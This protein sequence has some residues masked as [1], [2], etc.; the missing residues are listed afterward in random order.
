MCLLLTSPANAITFDVLVLPIDGFSNKENYYNFEEASEIIAND[1]IKDFNNTKGKIKSPDL[2]EVRAKL[3]KNSELKSTVISTLDKYKNT[4]RIDYAAVKKIGNDFS[5]KSVL[6]ISSSAVTN[7]NTNKR[8]IWEIL[9]ISS[10][11]QTS[12]PY[13][14][15]TSAVLLDTVNDL[16]MWSNNFSTKLGS[17]NNTF[18]AENFAQANAELEK[19][20]FYSEMIISPSISQNITLRFFPK[21]IRPL[22][23][24]IENNNGGALKFDRTVPEKPKQKNQNDVYSDDMIYGI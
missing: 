12:Y 15:E 16:V 6:I 22:D 21:S 4:N 20:K 5:C 11:F 3:N 17:N 23:K 13:R 1:V 19:V 10:V 2:Y 8:S 14:L 9:N 18:D 7:K 24:K